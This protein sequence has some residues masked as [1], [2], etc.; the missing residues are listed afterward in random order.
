MEKKQNLSMSHIKS[1]INEIKAAL[2]KECRLIAVSKFHPV[3]S[4]REAYD[5]GQR[6]FGESRVQEFVVKQAELP[7]DIEWHFIGHLQTNKVK[8]VVAIA[9]TIHSIDSSKLL[10]EVERYALKADRKIK[11][12]LQVHIAQED[13]KFGFDFQEC[14]ELLESDLVRSLKSVEIVG[15]MGMAT[16]TDNRELIKS[17]F[18]SLS[19][20]YNELRQTIMIDK[21]SFCELSMGMSDD[22]K[23]A[24]EEGST[25]VR[26]GSTIFGVRQ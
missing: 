11:C 25:Y 2:P 4:I 15:L 20:F 21:P 8:Q 13:T 3:E 14:R 1:K 6:I 10:A 16:Y 9:D 5:A 22:Y 7:K 24:V 26:I 18:N 17:E 23:L 19:S 12:L